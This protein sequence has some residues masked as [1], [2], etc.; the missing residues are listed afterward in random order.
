MDSE[1]RFNG[2]QDNCH[3][4]EKRVTGVVEVFPIDND[5]FRGIPNVFEAFNGPKTNFD[6]YHFI[7]W[8]HDR[9][10]QF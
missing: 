7:N 6:F 10:Q 2:G 3:V 1:P 8:V 5:Y 4:V 9:N